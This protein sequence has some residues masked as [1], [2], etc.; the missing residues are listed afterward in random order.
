[1]THSIADLNSRFGLAGKLEFCEGPGGLTVAKISTD[2]G[3]AM[4]SLSGGH[5]MTWQPTG[6]KPVLWLSGYAKFAPG[7]SIRGGVPVCWPWFGP[8]AT[9]AAFPGHG[10]ARTV[11]WQVESTAETA[12][13]AI[14]MVMVLEQS[15]STRSQWPHAGS[16]R[17]TLT[18]GRELRIELTTRNEGQEAFPLSE[19]LHTYF[20]VGDIRRAP[21]TGLDGCIYVD[22]VD[23]G[24][25]HTQSGAI[26]IGS[27]VDRVYVDTAADCLIED[28]SLNRRI[29]I[30]KEGSQSTVVW[31]PWAAKAEKM[32]DFGPDGHLGMVC[33]ESGNALENTLTLAPGASH[34]M[35]AIYSVEA[36]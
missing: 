30:R 2:Q 19:A 24:A 6:Q 10:F 26:V 15:D 33:V 4:V 14:C 11:A 21:I 22:K 27:E 25:R 3:E 28:A 32:G 31:N 20:A 34:S 13:G 5:V 9:E 1:M 12:D 36:L 35:T 29:R 23:G 7:K 16:V 17:T 18:I 8:H